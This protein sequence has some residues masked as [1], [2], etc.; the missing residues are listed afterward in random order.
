MVHHYPSVQAPPTTDLY[1]KMYLP[2]CADVSQKDMFLYAVNQFI[3]SAHS[4]C[5][6]LTVGS[7]RYMT[8]YT[9]LS[10]RARREVVSNPPEML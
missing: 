10:Q 4:R 9:P 2:V 1:A 7:T 6:H 8:F 5:L 3:D